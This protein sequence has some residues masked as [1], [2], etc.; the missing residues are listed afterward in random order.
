MAYDIGMNLKQ[1]GDLERLVSKIATA[2]V[3]PRELVPTF[4]Y[5]RCSWNHKE[6]LVC[7]GEIYKKIAN[8]QC[9]ELLRN[10]NQGNIQRRSAGKRIG[11][12][13]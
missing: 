5:V 13:M 12:E 11:R 1:V 7:T 6:K 8:N 10:Q 4:A 2:K 9:L 3:N